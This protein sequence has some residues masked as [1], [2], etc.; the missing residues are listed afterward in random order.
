MRGAAWLGGIA[1]AACGGPAPGPS[2][3][4]FLDGAVR[5]DGAGAAGLPGAQAIP[6]GAVVA[7]PWAPGERV[8]LAGQ[9]AVAP[10]EPQCEALFA[11][12]LG[13]ARATVAAG[14]FPEAALAFSPDGATLAVGTQDGVLRVLDAWTGALRASRSL[15]EAAIKQVAWSADGA[16]LYVTEQ[17]PDAT[18]HAL[19]PASLGPRWSRRL[20]DEVE[21][22]AP[23]AAGDAYGM[24]TLPAGYGLSALPDGGLL[25]A[26]AHA[27]AGADGVTQNRSVVLR[28]GADGAPRARWPAAG[29]ADTVLRHLAV[30]AAG[31]RAAVTVNRSAAGP[32]AAD[33]PPDGVLPFDLATLTP[34]A[35]VVPDPLPPWFPA[36]FVW[37]GL[38]VAGGRLGI[39]LGDGR[40]VLYGAD[41]RPQASAAPGA[42]LL[43]GEVPIHASVGWGRFVGADF[44]VTVSGTLIPWGAASP[45]LRPPS[46]HPEART[47]RAFGPDGALRWS[48]PTEAEPQGLTL[49]P[50]GA[51]LAVGLG[52]ASGAAAA[53]DGGYGALRMRAGGPAAPVPVRCPTRG[54]VFFRQALTADGRLAVVE[55]PVLGPGQIVEGA[56][57]VVVLR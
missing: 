47:V 53:L 37:E 54:P 48:L 52:V 15:P 6:G 33:T 43:A 42:P 27:W 56:W 20:A 23:P 16:T 9:R 30:D 8:E 11:V 34:G 38:D 51:W 49:S 36:P 46:P 24:W 2:R 45:E 7:R 28:L 14:N 40:V 32:R 31:G 12:D 10:P 50:D 17:S 57:R 29:A 22:S 4:V 1:L 19:D 55:A 5:V 26:A 3:L 18:L 44:V 13:D 21:T 35:P 25:V 39:G 41:G